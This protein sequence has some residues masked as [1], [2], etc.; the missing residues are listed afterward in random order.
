MTTHRLFIMF[1]TFL[2]LFFAG[3]GECSPNFRMQGRMQMEIIL[4]RVSFMIPA[5][6]SGGINLKSLGVPQVLLQITRDLNG[7][8]TVTYHYN[9][10]KDSGRLEVQAGMYIQEFWANRED[11]QYVKFTQMGNSGEM[12]LET[13][14]MTPEMWTYLEESF[15][16]P[17]DWSKF[18]VGESVATNIQTW[19][20]KS[21]WELLFFQTP[22]CHQALEKIWKYQTGK[23]NILT[24]L[25]REF[26]TVLIQ[27][28][29]K[30]API[31]EEE[32]SKTGTE[33]GART[34]T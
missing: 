30:M 13:G 18:S 11:D 8:A 17:T 20:A 6:R 3:R 4:G 29:Q 7:M 16:K 23:E 5:E 28:D 21:V 27:N 34:E 32:E 9:G 26:I 19:R 10:K 25:R 22:E 12:M 15:E 2:S 33:T 31:F 14:K 1:I 24:Q